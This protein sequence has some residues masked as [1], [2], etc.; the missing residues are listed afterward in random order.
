[1][2]SVL[3]TQTFQEQFYIFLNKK[4]IFLQ[5]PEGVNKMPTKLFC[6]DA[7]ISHSF[8][9]LVPRKFEDSK[10]GKED[11]ANITVLN[12]YRTVYKRVGIFVYIYSAELAVILGI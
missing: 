12:M 5:I 1:M 7:C 9:T 4:P 8:F 2:A 11:S 6:N 3:Q 10:K